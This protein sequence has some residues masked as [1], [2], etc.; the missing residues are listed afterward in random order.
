MND[1]LWGYG[2]PIETNAENREFSSGPLVV[3]KA[4]FEPMPICVARAI[5]EI[6]DVPP[7]EVFG[8]F[9][10]SQPCPVPKEQIDVDQMNH[11]YETKRISVDKRTHKIRFENET[12]NEVVIVIEPK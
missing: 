11:E 2:S 9:P 3:G 7:S 1:E 5:G 10:Y 8:G 6:F 4:V 12:E